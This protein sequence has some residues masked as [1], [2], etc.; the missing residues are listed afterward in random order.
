MPRRDAA[1]ALP[2]WEAQC[3]GPEGLSGI[4]E[5]SAPRQGTYVPI[6]GVSRRVV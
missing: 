5:V 3:P 1:I 4:S 6:P 2:G